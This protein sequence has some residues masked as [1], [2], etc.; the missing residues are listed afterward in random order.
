VVPPRYAAA[1]ALLVCLGVGVAFGLVVTAG[2]RAVEQ[3]AQRA[4][5]TD[6]ALVEVVMAEQRLLDE[7]D[8]AGLG[9]K[10]LR[11]RH[12][13]VMSAAPDERL[14]RALAF[15]EA[16]SDAVEPARG[17]ALVPAEVRSVEGVD[18]LRVAVDARRRAHEDW[19][20]TA[21]SASGQLALT[22]SLAEPPDEL[23]PP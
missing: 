1:L 16:A 8:A 12:A 11:A 21:A 15:V 4:H 3:A 20:Q 13:E 22:V 23:T 6:V 10:E 7:L 14:A 5:D 2:A 18:R 9:S 19:Q 17:R